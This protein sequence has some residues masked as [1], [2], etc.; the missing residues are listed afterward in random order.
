MTKK[1]LERAVE[2]GL[3][4]AIAD[5]ASN[6]KPEGRVKGMLERIQK[7]VDKELVGI[8][9]ITKSEKLHVLNKYDAFAKKAGWT[10]KNKY[11][12]ITTYLSFVLA[13]LE[14]SKHQHSSKLTET[15]VKLFDHFERA[16]KARQ[17]NMW[18][19]ALAAEKWNSVK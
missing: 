16:G 1:E 17:P 9:I 10:G 13:L 15:I 11:K 18:S 3:C 5:M 6:Q 2:L 4:R 14:D 8:P 12:D 7:L 19:G